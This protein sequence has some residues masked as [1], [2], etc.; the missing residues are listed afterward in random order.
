MRPGVCW[1]RCGAAA[2]GPVSDGAMMAGCIRLSSQARQN[3]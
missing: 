1:Q 2:A 3:L